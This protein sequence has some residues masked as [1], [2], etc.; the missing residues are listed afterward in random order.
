MYFLHLSVH[1]ELVRVVLL[2]LAGSLGG[3]MGVVMGVGLSQKS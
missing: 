2:F 1:L 3:T